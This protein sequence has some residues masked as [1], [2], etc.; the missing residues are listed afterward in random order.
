MPKVKT[1][2]PG[3]KPTGFVVGAPR[4]LLRIE[5]A[6]VALGALVAY[7]HFGGSWWMFVILIMLPDTALFGYLIDNRVGVVCYDAV[8][9]SFPAALM[10]IVGLLDDSRTLMC[11][12][13]IWLAHIGIERMMGLGLRY[14][15]G[16][17]YTHLG[18]FKMK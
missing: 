5:G 10:A 15:D 7:G 2:D 9:T 3:V 6:V 13:A 14:G 11:L 16:F 18:K 12:A 4:V 17:A 1:F 8:H